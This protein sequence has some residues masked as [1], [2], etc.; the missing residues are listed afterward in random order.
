MTV[1]AAAWELILAFADDELI[2]GHRH[3]EWLGV[4]PYMEEDL[5][6]ASIAQDELGHARALYGLL[7]DDLDAL[8]F[9]RPSSEYRSCW[10]VE[11]PTTLWEDAL[12]RH[13]LYDTAE[14][15]RWDALR[16]SSVEGLSGVAAKALREE[17][18]HR[19]HA[20]SVL[21]RML[22]GTKES[23]ERIEAA[24]ARVVPFAR[25]LFEP[26]KG[27][28]EAL[29]EGVISDPAEELGRRWREE[30][31]PLFGQMQVDWSAASGSGGRQGVRSEHFQGLFAV[32]T[33]VLAADPSATW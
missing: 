1:T 11:L 25:G 17:R 20:Y 15:I 6:F 22:A 7:T 23:R 12:V 8:A 10:L 2:M 21:E 31:E 28:P 16:E 24:L 9:G 30:V 19:R 32:M 3:S 18:Y 26:T 5:A 13:V 33:D 4:A 29:A 14:R 27:E